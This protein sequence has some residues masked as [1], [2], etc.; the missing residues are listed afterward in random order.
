MLYFVTWN[1]PIIRELHDG[2]FVPIV[3]TIGKVALSLEQANQIVMDARIVRISEA[4][5]TFG[6]DHP[7]MSIIAQHKDG[8]RI[9]AYPCGCGWLEE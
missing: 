4:V 6:W 2:R 9:D 1:E 3:Q 8:M 7:V 5:L